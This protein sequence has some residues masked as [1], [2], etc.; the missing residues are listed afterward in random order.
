MTQN[1][2]VHDLEVQ[3][4][5]GF[6]YAIFVDVIDYYGIILSRLIYRN[7]LMLRL[8]LGDFGAGPLFARKQSSGGSHASY[9]TQLDTGGAKRT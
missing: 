9:S 1:R 4:K 3:L 8:L 6:R 5:G 2:R 7:T